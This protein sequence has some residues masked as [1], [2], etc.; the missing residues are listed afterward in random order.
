MFPCLSNRLCCDVRNLLFAAAAL[1]VGFAAGIAPTN[2]FGDEPSPHELQLTTERVVVFKDG[3]YLV[4]KRGTALADKEG[5]IFCDDVP[6]AAVLGSF[7]ATTE[8]GR[9]ISMTAGWETIHKTIEKEVSCTQPLDVLRANIGKTARVELQDKT[10]LNGEIRDV[11][12]EELHGGV[13]EALRTTFGLPAFPNE[14]RCR[15]ASECPRA[16]RLQ[17]S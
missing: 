3:F 4:I 12:V 6:D 7:W 8:K 13:P 1:A 10:S 14:R 2:V 15:R 11:L 5:D 9:I 16:N 17:P